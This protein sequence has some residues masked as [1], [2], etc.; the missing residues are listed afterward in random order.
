MLTMWR[1]I[2]LIATVTFSLIGIG[3]LVLAYALIGRFH[4]VT[5]VTLAK[6]AVII[7]VGFYLILTVVGWQ[8]STAAEAKPNALVAW[9]IRNHFA[10][11][12]PILFLFFLLGLGRGMDLNPIDRSVDAAEV[13]NRSCVAGARQQIVRTG[14]DPDSSSLKA[15]MSSYCGCLTARVQREYEPNEFAKLMDDPGRLGSDA[16]MSRIIDSCAKS[17]SN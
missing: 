9:L 7:P 10:P 17:A 8:R 6:L 15:R 16:K 12:L 13:M 14:G 4:G 1:R 11:F 5:V 3:L 2:R